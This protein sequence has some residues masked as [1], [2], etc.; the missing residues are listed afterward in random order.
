MLKRRLYISAPLVFA[1]SVFLLVVPLCPSA[2]ETFEV[3]SSEI[4]IFVYHRFGPVVADSMTVTAPVFDAQLKYLRE[5]GYTG[6]SLRQF[7]MYRLGYSPGAHPRHSSALVYGYFPLPVRYGMTVG[8]LA[9]MFNAENHIGAKL[10]VVT[11]P[12]FLWQ[13]RLCLLSATGSAV[14]K[15][16]RAIITQTPMAPTHISGASRLTQVCLLILPG[17]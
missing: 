5:H 9:R 14:Y 4:P 3:N 2:P 15:S 10:H 6:I 16:T 1:F 12:G 11:M 8:E 7:V 17:L 13:K